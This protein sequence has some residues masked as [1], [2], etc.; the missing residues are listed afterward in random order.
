MALIDRIAALFGRG[1]GAAVRTTADETALLRGPSPLDLAGEMAASRSRTAVIR[2]CRE[3]YG[4]DTRGKAVISRLAT[5]MVR[6]GFK[7]EMEPGG[8][9]QAAQ[10]IAD[11]LIARLNLELRLDDWVRLSLRDGDS[12][13]ELGV[14]D[15]MEISSVTRKPTLEMRR[16]SNSRDTF[17]DP[18]RA[19]WQGDEWVT[20]EPPLNAIWYAEWQ[21]IHARWHH[22]EG[23]R[24]GEP[25]FSAAA[26]P[27]KRMTEGETDLAVRRKTR[28]GVKFVHKFPAGTPEPE[29]RRYKEIN[30]DSLNNPTA[31]IADF[32]GTVDIAQLQGDAQLGQ[33]D[34]VMHHIRT[35]FL[36]SPAPMSL[37][38]YGQDLNRDVLDAQEQQYL[39]TLEGLESWP[40]TE[41]IRPLL[42]RQWLLKGILPDGLTYQIKWVSKA[43][44]TAAS[45]DQASTAAL[46][47]KALGAPDDAVRSVL[48][49][50]LPGVDFTAW[51]ALTPGPSPAGGRGETGPE[52]RATPGRMAQIAGEL[53]R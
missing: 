43:P 21:I 22:D 28:A 13:L 45:V 5:D 27:Y 2:A 16:N 42:E 48:E 3:M 10:E 30:K 17:D 46:K 11:A 15:R 39:R 24:Y 20:G 49:K 47:L 51:A 12:F 37:L 33:I 50:L 52:T 1:Q 7:V 14:D 38:G 35:W 25:L 8:Q 19:F 32:F 23:S 36:A 29:I 18:R 4:A 34:D 31:A 53:V 40:E 44:L 41:I 6:G 26:K 9:S